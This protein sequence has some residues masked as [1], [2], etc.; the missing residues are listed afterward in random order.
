VTRALSRLA[1]FTAEALPAKLYVTYAVLWV[2]GLEG[3]VTLLAEQRWIPGAGTVL[4]V[5]TV[6]FMLLYLRAVDE[7]KDL[8]Y[9]RLHHPG[10][11]L[12]RGSVTVTELRALMLVV[13]AVVLLA[14][15]SVSAPATL[16]LVLDLGYALLL[17][18]VERRSAWFRDSLLVN[19]AVTY[20]V[21]LLLSVYVCLSAVGTVH[22]GAVTM[23]AAVFLHFEFARKTRWSAPPDGRFYSNVVGPRGSALLAAGTATVA[24]V[25]ALALLRPWQAE[26]A[27][28]V[29]G[30]LPAGALALVVVAGWRFLSRS[31]RA[32]PGGLAMS[33][34][35][36]VY[37]GCIIHAAVAS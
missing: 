16:V 33:F 2:I 28:A 30:W 36:W 5:A 21:Q 24:A 6:W 20:P 34:L 12:V 15:V 23:F 14:N 31:T 37:A 26:G 22:W 1:S 10:R 27:A 32:W 35:V 4:R 18:A 13:A 17:V 25:L 7:Q 19:L 11:P 9:D 8:D 29:T 3:M